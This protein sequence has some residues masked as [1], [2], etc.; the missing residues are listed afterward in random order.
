[1]T[2]LLGLAGSFVGGF[3]SRLI[4]RPEEGSL[5]HPAGIIMSVVGAILLLVVWHLV[6][7]KTA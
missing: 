2:I 6:R 1:M 7:P 4:W 5:I 3:V